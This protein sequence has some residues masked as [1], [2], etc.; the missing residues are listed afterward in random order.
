MFTLLQGCT[1]VC[2]DVTHHS[3]T[4]LVWVRLQLTT[5]SDAGVVKTAKHSFSKSYLTLTLY[6][7]LFIHLNTD[8]YEPASIV[9]IINGTAAKGAVFHSLVQSRDAILLLACKVYEWNSNSLQ[10]TI[11]EN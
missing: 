9:S 6:L 8:F 5:V 1:G 7:G 4:L 3:S 2:Q 11:Q 10:A